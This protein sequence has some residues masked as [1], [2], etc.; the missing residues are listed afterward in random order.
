MCLGEYE[1]KQWGRSRNLFAWVGRKHTAT[2]VVCNEWYWEGTGRLTLVRFHDAK[3]SHILGCDNE[4][5]HEWFLMFQISVVPSSSCVRQISIL[6]G[7]STPACKAISC[8]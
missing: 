7:L 5:M 1:E 6:L 8:L 2:A 3:D 4:L